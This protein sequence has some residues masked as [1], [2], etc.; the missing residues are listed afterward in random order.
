MSRKARRKQLTVVPTFSRW[1]ARLLEANHPHRCLHSFLRWNAVATG[2][3]KRQLHKPTVRTK[4]LH[5]FILCEQI[6]PTNPQDSSSVPS[7]WV[8]QS[9]Y[10]LEPGLWTAKRLCN[11]SWSTA[12]CETVCQNRLKCLAKLFEVK[13]V[14][15]VYENA[16][17]S[18]RHTFA[19][20]CS[21]P[22]CVCWPP[23]QDVWSLANTSLCCLHYYCLHIVL[24]L[25]THITMYHINRTVPLEFCMPLFKSIFKKGKENACRQD[26]NLALYGHHKM[27]TPQHIPHVYL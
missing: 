6:L 24:L 16:Q 18:A 2:K 5:E 19:V 25:A 20:S 15:Y 22:Q 14:N 7:T 26:T 9:T 17:S 4:I 23:D 8:R 10:L 21:C 11:Q 27:L 1:P 3:E 13:I 12:V